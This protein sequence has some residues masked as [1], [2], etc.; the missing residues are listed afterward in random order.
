MKHQLKRQDRPGSTPEF[1][2]S[3]ANSSSWLYQ[4]LWTFV[5]QSLVA[6]A[7]FVALSK[8]QRSFQCS[9]WTGLNNSSGI[10][11]FSSSSIFSFKYFKYNSSEA[12]AQVSASLT[13]IL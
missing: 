12:Y 8:S 10:L 5:N 9:G 11:Q 4:E 6:R 13:P 1:L 2:H 7:G 3:M